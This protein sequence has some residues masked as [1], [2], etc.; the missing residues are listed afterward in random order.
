M[1]KDL[2]SEEQ[3]FEFLFYAQRKEFSR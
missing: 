1:H 3:N 2:N